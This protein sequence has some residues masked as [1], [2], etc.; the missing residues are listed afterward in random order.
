MMIIQISSGLQTISERLAWCIRKSIG[1]DITSD[2]AD[3]QCKW[4]QKGRVMVSME[5]KEETKNTL[6]VKLV[7]YHE[8]GQLID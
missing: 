3:A 6:A 1:S 2:I 5:T 7:A 4:A 8:D